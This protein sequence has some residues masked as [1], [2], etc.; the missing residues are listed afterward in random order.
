ME[1]KLLIR[2]LCSHLFFHLFRLHHHRY[3]HLLEEHRPPAAAPV[4]GNAPDPNAA[5]L[6]GVLMATQAMTQMNIESD[7][8]N[9]SMTQQQ[10]SLQVA[11]M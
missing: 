7:L 11:L 6:Q 1:Y 9:T 2:L 4:V 10:S 5:F 3:S 8:R